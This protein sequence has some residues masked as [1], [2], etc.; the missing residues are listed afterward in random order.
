VWHGF[1][2]GTVVSRRGA[3]LTQLAL[4]SR[5][6]IPFCVMY[7]SLKIVEQPTRGPAPW[8]SA[9]LRCDYMHSFWNRAK[10]RQVMRE[11]VMWRLRPATPGL[12]VPS[13]SWFRNATREICGRIPEYPCRTFVP[14]S[15]KPVFLPLSERTPFLPIFH[16]HPLWLKWLALSD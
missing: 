10:R 8:L 6:S 9:S 16:R 4:I 5:M 1:L 15:A 13:K 12:I 3:Q 11:R 7:Q 14:F 2:I